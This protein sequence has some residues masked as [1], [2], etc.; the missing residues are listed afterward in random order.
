M[1]AWWLPDDCL[2]AAWWLHD[3]CQKTAW[4]LTQ[5][6]D[7]RRNLP[8]NHIPLQQSHSA[9]LWLN[10]WNIHRL[11]Y[12]CSSRLFWGHKLKWRPFSFLLVFRCNVA[13]QHDESLIHLHIFQASTNKDTPRCLNESTTP[14]RQWGFRQYLPF[15]WTTLRGK[16]YWHLI[17]VMY[18]WAVPQVVLLS[19]VE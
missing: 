16:H 11:W 3:D 12:D 15:S 9:Q 13:W 7:L 19:L 1:T 10:Q 4:W 8:K 5:D 18:V 14:L 2:M 17:D 6:K